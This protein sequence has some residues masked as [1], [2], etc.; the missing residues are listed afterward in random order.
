MHNRIP[1]SHTVLVMLVMLGLK[2]LTIDYYGWSIRIRSR[3][4][5]R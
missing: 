3:R 4:E 5:C 1:R 2:K